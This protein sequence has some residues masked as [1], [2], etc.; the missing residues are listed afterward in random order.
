MPDFKIEGISAVPK[1]KSLTQPNYTKAGE[2]LMRLFQGPPSPPTKEGW[3]AAPDDKSL[4]AKLRQHI[5][6]ELQ[7]TISKLEE[8]VSIAGPNPL[9]LGGGGKAASLMDLITSDKVP[10]RFKQLAM[11]YA[12]V[13][14]DEAESLVRSSKFVRR[15]ED[16]K[17]PLAVIMGTYN[18]KLDMSVHALEDQ[19]GTPLS[20]MR[21]LDTAGHEIKGHGGDAAKYGRDLYR[22]LANQERAQGIKERDRFTETNAR[23]KAHEFLQWFIDN[24]HLTPE[25]AKVAKQL[26]EGDS[27]LT[28]QET[29]DMM[30]YMGFPA[31]KK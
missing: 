29:K 8:M 14:P 31:R 20:T 12:K 13:F 24:K 5:P 1:K 3:N 4:M 16:E 9:D 23:K 22:S 2:A 30:K 6:Q 17:D 7:D 11:K 15:I 25:E 28:V 18:P 10:P 21:L 27:S 26:I 19:F